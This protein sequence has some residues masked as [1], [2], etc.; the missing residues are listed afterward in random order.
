MQNPAKSRVTWDE[1]GDI[2]LEVSSRDE[3][4]VL[5]PV[6]RS[7]MSA[8]E[9][10]IPGAAEVSFEPVLGGQLGPRCHLF[11]RGQPVASAVNPRRSVGTM[12]ERAQPGQS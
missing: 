4:K 10:E 11:I 3:R 5:E 12:F 9:H 7:G 8:I 6:E 1:C 2:G